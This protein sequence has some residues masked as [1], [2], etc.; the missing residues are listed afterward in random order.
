MP[1]CGG[2][3]EHNGDL[4]QKVPFSHCCTH[5]PQPCSRPPLTHTS[6]GDSWTLMDKSGS[7][8]CGVSVPFYWVLVCTRFCLCPSKSLQPCISSIRSMV[9]LTVTSSKRTYSIP[10]SVAPRAPAIV[11]GHFWP[12]LLQETLKHSKAGLA[13]SPWGLLVHTRFCLSPLSV[14]G[15]HGV[16]F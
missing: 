6:A 1:N 13:Q 16:W 7:L 12:V 14:S 9:E 2:G 8:S 4:L 15:G 5:C 10:R 3:N 11:A